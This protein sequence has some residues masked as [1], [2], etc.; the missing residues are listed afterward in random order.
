MIFLR[1]EIRR[2]FIEEIVEHNR[3]LALGWG[4]DW[5]KDKLEKS[6]GG[7]WGKGKYLPQKQAVGR[8]GNGPL[9][10]GSR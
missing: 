1:Y 2:N 6:T 7:C 9:V 5:G 8:E 4:W 3:K 10:E